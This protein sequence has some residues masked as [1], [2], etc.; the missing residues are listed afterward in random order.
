MLDD[1]SLIP[2]NWG[3]LKVYQEKDG[4][5]AL[6]TAQRPNALHH[7]Q[8]SLKKLGRPFVASFCRAVNNQ[9]A[10]KVKLLNA[11]KDL[12]TNIRRQVEQELAC[13]AHIVEDWEYDRLKRCEATLNAIGLNPWITIGEADKRM[14]REARMLIN[15]MD[16]AKSGIESAIYELKNLKNQLS[17]LAKISEEQ[18]EREPI[19]MKEEHEET[20]SESRPAT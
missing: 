3:A 4:T 12:E 19:K 8:L 9:S 11:Q 14:H 17:N 20:K 13:G 10:T 5:L 18:E 7:E 2:V 15:R 6:K 1:L 16:S